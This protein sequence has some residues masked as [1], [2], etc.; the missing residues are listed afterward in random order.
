MHNLFIYIFIY[1]FIYHQNEI[2]PTKT[3]ITIDLKS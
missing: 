1:L 3:L 2:C